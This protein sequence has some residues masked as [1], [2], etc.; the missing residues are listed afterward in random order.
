MPE[1]TIDELLAAEASL[2]RSFT[3]CLIAFL[4]STAW[5]IYIRLTGQGGTSWAWPIGLLLLLPLLGTYVWFAYAAST[6]AARLGQE[7]SLYLAWLIAAP[8]LGRIPIPIVSQIIT[9]SPLSL[10]F[11]LSSQLRHEIHRRTLAD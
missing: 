6:A 10:K 8:V 2:D 5:P 9:V 3:A 4:V 11:L 1:P 7:R